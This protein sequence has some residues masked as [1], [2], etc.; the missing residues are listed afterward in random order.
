[1]TLLVNSIGAASFTRFISPIFPPKPEAHFVL[2]TKPGRDGFAAIYT[3]RWGEPFELL[4]ENIFDSSAN[5]NSAI[6]GYHTLPSLS[7]VNVVWE[8][9]NFAT[10]YNTNF[11][12]LSATVRSVRV[13][14]VVIA[15]TVTYSPAWIVETAFVLIPRAIPS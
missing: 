13:A 9:C 3:G 12:V 2:E 11:M 15:P 14:A 8:N 4:A 5:A 6:A 1:M 10:T 7:F